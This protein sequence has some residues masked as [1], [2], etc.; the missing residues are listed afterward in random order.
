M[1][2][3]P[4]RPA[5]GPPRAPRNDKARRNPRPIK[6]LHLFNVTGTLS[7]S[8]AGIPAC[9][10]LHNVV[11][12]LFI[13]WFGKGFWGPGGDEPV[14]FVLAI[15]VCPVLFLIGAAASGVLLLRARIKESKAAPQ[16]GAPP[17]ADKPGG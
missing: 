2:A 13:W 6:V 9:A 3:G 11:Y 8:A 14:F 16:Q 7:L 15:L 5:A 4:P 17:G 10:I 1:W 12:G